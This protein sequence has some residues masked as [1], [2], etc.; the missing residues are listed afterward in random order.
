MSEGKKS[1][2]YSKFRNLFKFWIIKTIFY[3]WFCRFADVIF[4]NKFCAFVFEKSQERLSVACQFLSTDT[5]VSIHTR[6][7]EHTKKKNNKKKK[8]TLGHI[9]TYSLPDSFIIIHHHHHH[10][11]HHQV[12]LIT[13]IPL[14]LSPSIP[15][16][17]WK[18]LYVPFIV[19][20]E[21]MNVNL[22]WSANP[23]V[24]MCWSP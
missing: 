19:R 17:S 7:H 22:F 21:L 23:G 16:C 1:L 18:V 6:T 14:I 13:R 24:S 9:L 4:K 12:V 10:H 8:N 11:H 15:I 3:F 5:H 20:L 2:E